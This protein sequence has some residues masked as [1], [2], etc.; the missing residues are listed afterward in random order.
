LYIF[1]PMY[2]DLGRLDGITIV[3]LSQYLL[4]PA[5]GTNKN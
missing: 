2:S 1:I 3:L 4:D 5:I